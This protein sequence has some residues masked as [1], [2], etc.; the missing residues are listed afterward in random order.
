[1]P[2]T[3]VLFGARLP[4]NV[5]AGT[6][7]N[8]F[9]GATIDHPIAF[10]IG[11]PVVS[12]LSADHTVLPGQADDVDTTFVLGLASTPGV[13]GDHVNVQPQGVLTLTRAQWDAITGDTGG[14]IWGIPY[15][16]DPATSGQ[17]TTT[18]PSD[19]GDFVVR[20]GVAL[21]ATDLLILICC[22]GEVPRN[23]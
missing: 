18:A 1:M 17:L 7:Y 12:S 9:V 10:P 14:L 19:P 4:T 13:V 15:Y 6:T 2:D 20:V 22:P 16:L 23:G 5:L 11:T 21:S 3:S 8:P